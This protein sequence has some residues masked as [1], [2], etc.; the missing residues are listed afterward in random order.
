MTLVTN[1]VPTEA[2]LGVELTGPAQAVIVN[3]V[4]T[5][6]VT[7]TNLGPDDAPGVQLINALSLR[8]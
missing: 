2:D 8:G 4:M 6:G 7:A 1:L 3:D 5:Y